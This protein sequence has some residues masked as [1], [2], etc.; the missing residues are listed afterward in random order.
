MDG[1]KFVTVAFVALWVWG[2]FAWKMCVHLQKATQ[3]DDPCFTPL[4]FSAFNIYSEKIDTVCMNV[5]CSFK[6]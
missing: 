5:Y 2:F 1:V 3:Q 6:Y 4:M